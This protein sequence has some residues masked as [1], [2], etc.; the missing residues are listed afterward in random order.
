[1]YIGLTVLGAAVIGLASYLL[2]RD[3]KEGEG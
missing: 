3:D 1:M 2:L